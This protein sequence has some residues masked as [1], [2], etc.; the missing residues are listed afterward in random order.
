MWWFWMRAGALTAVLALIALAFLAAALDEREAHRQWAVR[1][2]QSAAEQQVQ[3]ALQC[4]IQSMFD[5]VRR[6]S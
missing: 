3:H 2:R 1:S 6:S 5:A 4:T